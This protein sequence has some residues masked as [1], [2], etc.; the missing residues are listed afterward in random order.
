MALNTTYRRTD[1][2]ESMDD[3][4]MDNESL[5]IALDD[6]A[7]I[8]QL[9]GGNSVTLE[10]VKKLI[11]DFPKD[12]T[13]TIMDFGCGGGDMLR[14]LAKFGQ[15]N[16]LKFNLIGI[17]A[18]EATIRHAEKCSAEFE[19][20]SYLA[21]DIFEYDFSKYKIDIALITLTLHHFKDEGILKIVN[22]ILNLVTKGIVVNDLHRSRLAYRLFQMIIFIFR[23]KKMTADD[24]LISILR[25]F[26]REDLEKYSRNLQLKKYSIKWKWA[27]RYQWIIE[28]I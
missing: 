19:N 11:E 9:L 23:L 24:G 21:E 2:E 12:Q 5:V 26:K 27:F 6:I 7:R 8:N 17:D 3:F 25:G 20:I 15:E 14:M 1:L 22:V 16:G 10:G 18:N 4:S 28:K 13:I